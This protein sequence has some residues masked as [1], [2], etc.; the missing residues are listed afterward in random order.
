MKEL[1]ASKGLHLMEEECI[2]TVDIENVDVMN[3]RFGDEKN[4][5]LQ[6]GGI[7]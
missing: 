5:E 1:K 2:T 3:A 7:L 4:K 6:V